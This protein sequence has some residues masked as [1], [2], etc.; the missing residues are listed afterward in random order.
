MQAMAARI[1]GK[2]QENENGN[3]LYYALIQIAVPHWLL[4]KWDLRWIWARYACQINL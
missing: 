3:N 4:R 2:G 1:A